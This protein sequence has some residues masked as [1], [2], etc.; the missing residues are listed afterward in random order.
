[1]G[2]NALSLASVGAGRATATAIGSFG[3]IDCLA[4]TLI[5]VESGA[6]AFQRAGPCNG[7]LPTPGEPLLV[8]APGVADDLLRIWTEGG[9]NGD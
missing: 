5:A 7:A 6:R 2:S 3:P 4:G 1:M 8:V 9:R